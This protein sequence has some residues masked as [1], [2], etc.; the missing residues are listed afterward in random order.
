MVDRNDEVLPFATIWMDHENLLVFRGF[1]VKGQMKKIKETKMAK[2][3]LLIKEKIFIYEGSVCVCVIKRTA[4]NFDI[5]VSQ[6]STV[7]GTYRH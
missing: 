5:D 6:G 3:V 1:L 4:K 7:P 2:S